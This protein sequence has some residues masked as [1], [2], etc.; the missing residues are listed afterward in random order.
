[1]ETIMANGTESA[2][3][4]PAGTVMVI[5]DDEH[6]GMLLELLLVRHGYEVRRA[7]DGNQ[8]AHMIADSEQVPNLILLD[9][10]ML[11]FRDGFELMRVI[12]AR[13]GWNAVPV[14]MLTAKTMERDIVRA[15]DAGANDYI[16]KPFQPSELMARLR[17]F[18]RVKA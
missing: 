11:P 10:M 2:L 18:I 4:S 5:E 8:A 1:M 9:V 17:R 15:F 12:R 7:V 14:I 16:V 13:D 6:I 3:A